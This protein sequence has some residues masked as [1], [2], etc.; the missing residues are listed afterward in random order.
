MEKSNFA[1]YLDEE[2]PAFFSLVKRQNGER[3]QNGKD[4]FKSLED[5]IIRKMVKKKEDKK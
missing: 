5:S 4:W 2:Y 3:Y 1:K